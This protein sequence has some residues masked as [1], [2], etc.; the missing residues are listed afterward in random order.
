MMQTAEHKL[1][2][3]AWAVSAVLHGLIASLAIVFMGQIK[4]LPLKDVFEWEVSLVQPVVQ[5][6]KAEPAKPTPPVLAPK[7]Q[8]KATPSVEPVPH[9][10]TR[11]VQTIE[12]PAV[13]QRAVQQVI[14]A[15]K[16][17]EETVK[18]I[19]RTVAVQ[20]RESVTSAQQEVK[21]AQVQERSVEQVVQ[22][23]ATQESVRATPVLSPMAPVPITTSA[24]PIERVEHATT[25]E[26]SPV[27]QSEPIRQAAPVVTHQPVVEAPTAPVVAAS[28]PPAQPRS[29]SASSV[30]PAIEPAAIAPPVQTYEQAPVVANAEPVR[31]SVKADLSWLA[32]SLRRRLSELRRYPSAA[33]L[34]GWEGK[35]VLRAVIGA[36]GHLREV[37][38]HRSSGYEVL[39]NAAIETIRLACPLRMQHEL[40]AD[41]VAVYVPIVY[42]L[43]G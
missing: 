23:E 38:V 16:P 28:P 15:S 14:E 39:D 18:P 34:N 12:K 36:D 32:E 7:P 4:P 24:Q 20:E 35:V 19:E 8:P 41:H 10:V 21:Q 25:V 29:S 30:A 6:P 40:K 9:V 33:R 42:S 2:L 5:A 3:Q 26:P 11:Q 1:Q 22:T 27:V 13:V 37:K 17:T 31:K 43:A